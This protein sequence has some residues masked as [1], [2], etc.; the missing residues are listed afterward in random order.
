M[1]LRLG[2]L[3]LSLPSVA[4]VWHKG[5]GGGCSDQTATP[6]HPRDIFVTVDVL[7]QTPGE[8]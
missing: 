8:I 1:L 4:L 2:S 7:G 3:M 5:L 6:S